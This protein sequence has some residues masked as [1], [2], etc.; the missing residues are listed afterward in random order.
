MHIETIFEGHDII[1]MACYRIT[2]NTDQGLNE[3]EADDLLEA[4]QQYIK[5]RKWGMV[6]RLEI[7]DGMSLE[8]LE[9]LIREFEVPRETVYEINGPLV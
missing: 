5:K 1:T 6:I 9:I 8:L 3:E 4:I 2:R 7:E